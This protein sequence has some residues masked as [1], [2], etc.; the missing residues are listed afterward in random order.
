MLDAVAVLQIPSQIRESLACLDVISGK[1][2]I[3]RIHPVA[4]DDMFSW[5]RHDHLLTVEPVTL[6]RVL[7]CSLHY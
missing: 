1:K 6:T 7:A 3:F 5:L 2:N 4:L